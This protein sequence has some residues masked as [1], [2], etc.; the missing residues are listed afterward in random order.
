MKKNSVNY[1]PEIDGLR[2]LAVIS[3]I[4]YHSEF[5]LFGENFFKGGFLGVDIFFVISG[6]LITSIIVKNNQKKNFSLATF[7]KNRVKRI[8]PALIFILSLNLIIGFFIL[9][10]NQLI[11][12]AYSYISSI[13]FVSNYFFYIS[14]Q[15]YTA[16][17]SFLI[18]F[19]HTWSLGVEEQFYIIY[20][21][22]FLFLCRLIK[23]RNVIIFLFLISLLFS[24]Y[25]ENINPSL[26]FYLFFS[27][28][29]ELM[30]GGI[31]ACFSF[32]FLKKTNNFNSTLSFL[33][34]LIILFSFLFASHRLAHPSFYTLIPTFGTAI[35]IATSGNSKFFVN[36]ILSSKTINFIGKISFS[37]YLWHYPILAYAKILEIFNVSILINFIIYMV[38]F[39]FSYL[40]YL[41]IEQPFRNKVT[42]K[43]IIN[44]LLPISLFF[45]FCSAYIIYK[46]GMPQ[47]FP[48]L[49]LKHF[50]DSHPYHLVKNKHSS[51]C[52][53]RIC[54]FNSQYDYEIFLLGD[55]NVATLQKPLLDLSIKKGFKFTSLT[56]DGCSY[57]DGFEKKSKETKKING[58][59]NSDYQ[60]K[61]NLILSN[62]NSSVIIG[63][64]MPLYLSGY[65]F[66]NKE[67][68]IENGEWPNY[69]NEINGNSKNNQT[70]KKK[71]KENFI[72]SIYEILNNGNQVILIYPIPEIGW[73]PIRKLINDSYFS[74][75]KMMDI[76]SNNSIST[77]YK[78]YEER[79]KE[80]FNLYDAIK[81][82]NLKRIYPHKLFCNNLIE[83]RCIFNNSKKIFYYD[84][85]HLSLDGSKLLLKL[86]AKELKR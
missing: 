67:G 9:L 73:N 6:Y 43:K 31:F 70:N 62:P 72:K 71:F 5:V 61:R 51:Y 84:D 83:N 37:L 81:H 25:Y 36:T 34:L 46:N 53:N 66:D 48:E 8:F 39:L 18:P 59:T 56:N 78:I 74:K 35:I 63:Q 14:G 4:F 76:L 47:R 64:R 20:P 44:I 7:Y 52:H 54:T 12:L 69:F 45:L 60:L 75:S 3:V 15:E 19:L 24:H 13:F 23:F 27:R 58:C 2:C 38:I 16:T 41:F 86:V 17:N 77:S 29:W 80:T 49:I 65:Y 10:P 57:V 55:S 68:G 1:I 33:G 42:F 85:D 11:E 30:L 50:K 32:N 40:T 82:N 22:I 26:N 79:A 21:L 28:I